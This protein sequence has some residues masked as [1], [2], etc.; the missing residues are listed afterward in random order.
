MDDATRRK[1]TTLEEVERAL[2]ERCVGRS[3]AD[4]KRLSEFI[5]AEINALCASAEGQKD[6]KPREN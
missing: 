6:A 4:L 3:Y 2:E 1:M 5:R